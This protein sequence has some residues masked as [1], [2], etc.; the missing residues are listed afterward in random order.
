MPYV[1][2]RVHAVGGSCLRNV[3]FYSL[4][5]AIPRHINV[6]APLIC[7]TPSTNGELPV[8]AQDVFGCIDGQLLKGKMVYIFFLA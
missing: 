4:G 7:S 5:S 1:R 8:C 6:P 2:P 3:D